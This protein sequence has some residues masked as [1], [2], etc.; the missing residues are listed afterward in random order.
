MA[1]PCAAGGGQVWSQPPQCAGSLASSTQLPPHRSGALPGQPPVQLELL[2]QPRPAL[3]SN[4]PDRQA[5]P[6]LQRPSAQLTR[7]G[8]TCGSWVQSLSQPP[9]WRGSRSVVAGSHA[10]PLPPVPPRPPAPPLPP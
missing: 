4:Q 10:P 6:R 8:S 9:Q 5:P 3:Q 2:S 1:T 7:V